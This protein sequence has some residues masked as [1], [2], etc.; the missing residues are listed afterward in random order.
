MSTT[1]LHIIELVKS[2]PLADQRAICVE[3]AKRMADLDLPMSELGDETLEI[4]AEDMQGLED[5]DPFFRV[6]KEVEAA[7]HTYPGRSAPQF[8]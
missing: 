4:S 2:L 1:A 5:D 6:M 8:D 3:L 7:R